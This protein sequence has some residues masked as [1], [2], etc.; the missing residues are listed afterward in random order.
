[1]LGQLLLCGLFLLSPLRAQTEATIHQEFSY[2]LPKP[3]LTWTAV[4]GLPSGLRIIRED[5]RIWGAPNEAGHYRLP[6]RASDGTQITLDLKVNALWNLS[7][8]PPQAA[9]GVPFSHAQVIGG[10]VPPYSFSASQ[11]PAGLKMSPDGIISGVPTQAGAYSALISV[12]DKQGNTLNLPYKLNVNP[13]GISTV[14]L[15]PAEAGAAAYSQQLTAAG[16]KPPYT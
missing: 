2:Q 3:A 1:M 16:G 9:V 7:L 8:T 10:G 14:D 15:P 13:I 11:L 4:E 12:A 6:L 5:A